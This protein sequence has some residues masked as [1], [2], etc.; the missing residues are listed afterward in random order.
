MSKFIEKVIQAVRTVP[1][2]Q[3][4]SYGQIAL[5]IGTPRAALQVG[6]ILHDYGDDGTTPWW[7]IINK[8]GYISTNCEEHTSL[9]Q[10]DL[11][12]KEGIKVSKELQVDMS[13]FRFIPDAE[14]LKK[15]ELD[16][17][18]IELLYNKYLN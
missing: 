16:D 4:A 2:G 10:K 11:L 5:M 13:V 14:L 17:R 15:L 18:Y 6:Y 9:M 1:H 12:E 3:V 7:R 8:E